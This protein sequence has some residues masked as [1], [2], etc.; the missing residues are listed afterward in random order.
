MWLHESLGR[1][2]NQ[3]RSEEVRQSCADTVATACPYCMTMLDDGLKSLDLERSP[4]VMDIIEI[5]ASSLKLGRE[6]R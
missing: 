6:Q 1:K 2:I 4:K 5:V 3:M